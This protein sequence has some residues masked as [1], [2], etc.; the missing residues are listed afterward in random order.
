MKNKRIFHL[1]ITFLTGTALL[2]AI[3]PCHAQGITPTS[4][5]T[6]AFDFASDTAS[7]IYWYGLGFNN[8][9]MTWDGTKDARSNANSGALMVSLPFTNSG[10]Q[11]VFFGTFHNQG[12]YDG[13]TIYDGTKFTNITFDLYF[14]PGGAY[15]SPAGDLGTLQVGLVQQ[16][17]QHGGTFYGNGLSIP[18]DATNRWAHLSQTVDQSSA[19]LDAVAGIDFKYTSYSG[20]PTNPVTFWIDN[21]IVHLAPVKAGPPTLA[22]PARPV[23]GLNLFSS[24]GNGDQYQRTSLKLNNNIGNQWLGA[25]GPVTYSFTITNFPSGAT[26]SGYQGHIFLVTGSTIPSYET[27]PD[28]AETNLIFLEVHQNANGTGVGY[29][30]YK[31]NEWQSNTNMFGPPYVGPASAGTP[32]LLN[33]PDVLGTWSITFN[34]DTNVTLAGPGGAV[35]NFTLPLGIVTNFPDPL[36]VIFGGE[37]NSPANFGQDVVL[38]A[39]S[40]SGNVVP[41]SDDFL[42]DAVL[43]TGTWSPLSGDINMVQL[44]VPDPG[45]WWVKWSLPDSGFGL[46]TTKKLA[47]PSVWVTLTGPDAVAGPFTSFSSSGSRFVLVPG[48]VLGT[49]SPAF[50]RLKQQV[51]TKLQ[52]LLPGETTARGTPTG[53]TGT[54][55]SQAVG[56]PFNVTVNA[57]DNNWTTISNI[58]DT[59]HITSTD[60]GPNGALLPADAALVNGTGTFSLI[61]QDPGS[62]T[63][64]AGDVTDNTKTSGTSSSVTV[65]P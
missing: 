36:N 2:A 35:T 27:A 4:D 56:V 23:T 7:W 15:L 6:N 31:V 49:N 58:T 50:F 24:A 18:P 46:Q 29:F 48:S 8:T 21:L 13:A 28:Y 60:T 12:A 44:I 1:G 40:V 14:A 41:V 22:S 54:P 38:S 43:D 37:P 5:Y 19:G 59:V 55:G 42:A 34:Q 17:W 9:A 32:V 47:Q 62:F 64:T 3:V 63:V 33:A 16:G 39:A 52:V 30:R 25:L 20:Y 61:F 45:A 26:H 57:V 65:A 51:F 53:K 11:A 10:D